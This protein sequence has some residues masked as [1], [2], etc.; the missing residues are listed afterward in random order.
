MK[1]KAASQW[2]LEFSS[3]ASVLLCIA[4]TARGEIIAP[5]TPDQ[6]TLHLWHMNEQVS[7]LSDS[8]SD[9]LQ[10]RALENGATLG[11]E[12]FIGA[13]NFGTALGT[14]VGNP[15]VAPGCAGQNAYL[16]AHP[17]QN[18][19]EDNV[20]L[21]YAGTDHAFTYEAIV[22]IDF[23][24]AANFGPDGW[25][26]RR[27]SFMQIISGDADEN[28]DRVFQFRIAP[29]GTLSNNL[30]P[31]LEFINLNKGNSVQSL[32]A[33]LPTDGP[34]AMRAGN[35]YHVA[36]SYSGQ[37]DTK[38][39]LKLYWSLVQ[40]KR[41]AANLIGVGQMTHNLPGDCSPDFAIG[42]TGR[43]SPV[44]PAPNNNFVGLIDEVRISGVARLPGEMLF[45]ETTLA[46]KKAPAS[47]NLAVSKS[48]EKKEAVTSQ[49][50]AAVKVSAP[51]P[52]AI[53][54]VA[55]GVSVINGAIAR[56]PQS[57][58]R[59]AILFSCRE[60]DAA[61]VSML[62]TLKAQQVKA[63]FFVNS[64]FL[65]QSVNRQLVQSILADGHYV[66][67][68][69]DTWSRFSKDE[70]APGSNASAPAE[71][72]LHLAG[73]A[74]LGVNREH[75]RY[76]L[77]TSDQLTPAIAE[78]AR[79]LGLT[80]V[81]GTPGTLSF[82]TTTVENTSDFVSSQAIIDSIFNVDREEKGLNGFLLLFPLDSGARRAD[83]FD[84]RFGDFLSA[85][86]LR[87]YE[88][89]RVDE[90][91]DGTAKKKDGSSFATLKHP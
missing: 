77:P 13:K 56:G 59:V 65:S 28:A 11:N 41:S 62:R 17:L 73:L 25:G 68:Q 51:V 76:F 2:I 4:L 14:Y 21:R 31:L 18:G 55:E 27:S 5:Y 75:L 32:T 26:K 16:A 72:E 34:E 66:G 38:D 1:T 36:V 91:L 40:P 3:A 81:A 45:G 7:P 47:T 12:S 50:P 29:M 74:G 80:M 15:A 24:P 48:P 53:T 30:Q 83:R 19:R 87:G 39:N 8:T 33:V 70:R 37:A 67:P 90:L 71:I 54:Q 23:D 6:H 44:T 64:T 57:A 61:A 58:P 52:T 89:V 46:G 84:A 79:A 49:T 20:T 82:A 22:R 9:G 10:L 42:Q 86:T 35:W 78:Q 60:S 43:Q 63:S 88:F 69:S 85:L